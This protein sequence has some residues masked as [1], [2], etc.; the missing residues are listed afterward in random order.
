[1][2]LSVALFQSSLHWKDVAGNLAFFS[3]LITQEHGDADLIILPEMFLTGFVV[4]PAAYAIEADGEEI[5]QLKRLSSEKQAV[6]CGSVI[7]RE[8][9]HYYN[10]L[11]WIHPDGTVTH[12]DKR[13]LFSF[14]GES[15]RFVAG[16][17]N[18]IETINDFRVQPQVCYDLRFPVWARNSYREETGFG[19]DLL[20]YTANWP[21]SR[22]EVWK[23][24]LKARAIENQC[25]VIG[26][27]RVGTDGEGLTYSGDSMIINARGEVVASAPPSQEHLLEY[28]L[29]REELDKFR[30]DFFIG[31]DWDSFSIN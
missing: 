10:R 24:L 19:Y 17:K 8:G 18:L 27:N 13:H 26:V 6:I 5:G 30:K 23:A 21:A 28:V 1:M 25:Y 16:E 14:G 12:Y 9:S 29:H 22:A 15:R 31:N 20:I 7:L 2:K 4:D 11:L 3:R